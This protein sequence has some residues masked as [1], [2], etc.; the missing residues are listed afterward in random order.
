MGEFDPRFTRLKILLILAI[1]YFFIISCE[2]VFLT[3]TAESDPFGKDMSTP[4]D[5]EDKNESL[6]AVG[7]IIVIIAQVMTFTLPELDGWMM[8]IMTP[9]MS[10]C[11]IIMVY[12]IIDMAYSWIKA[13]PLT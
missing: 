11:L 13:L 2:V 10:L 6:L 8:A 3:G 9:I 1:F 12:I 7:D 5:Y 4:V